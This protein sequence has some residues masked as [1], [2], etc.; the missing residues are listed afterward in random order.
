MK[1]ML[2]IMALAM[3]IAS[4]AAA[5]TVRFEP[6]VT[7]VAAGQVF[8]IDLV[9]D[10]DEPVL[11]F[12]L[13]VSFD[14]TRI[15]LLAPPAIGGAWT[16]VFAPDGDGLAGLGPVAGVTGDAV[17]LATL[18]FQAIGLGTT[19]LTAGV[20]A[21]D[22]AEGFPLV[23][24]GFADVAFLAGQVEVRSIPEPAPALLLGLGLG[25]LAASRGGGEREHQR[26]RRPRPHPRG[27]GGPGGVPGVPEDAHGR[28]PAL[29]GAAAG[30]AEGHWPWR[31]QPIRVGRRK[32]FAR[33]YGERLGTI[34]AN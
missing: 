2:P 3:A 26:A 30:G 34:D 24:G 12:G 1:R 9:A 31:P 22:L 15:G 6:G 21:D 19:P 4:P 10:L 33:Q 25:M 5:V 11:G 20:T 17:L 16:P 23:G 14:A 32:I 27:G 8:T 28:L 29:R 18:S 7:N 13:D